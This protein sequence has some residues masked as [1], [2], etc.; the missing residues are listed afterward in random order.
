MIQTL[1]YNVK[2]NTQNYD[3][4]VYTHNS[5]FTDTVAH[6]SSN[7]SL[8]IFRVHDEKGIRYAPVSVPSIEALHQ[9]ISSESDSPC[10][11]ACS[12]VIKKN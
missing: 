9:Y 10:M 12:L 3:V 2:T 1:E 11:Y 4:V 5:G 8:H 7:G 6:D